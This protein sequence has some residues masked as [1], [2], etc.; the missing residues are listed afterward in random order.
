MSDTRKRWAGRAGLACGFV[1]CGLLSPVGAQQMTDAQKSAIRDNCRSDYMQHCSSVPP[2]TAQSLA[3]LQQNAGKVSAACQR[4]L[5][6]V[7]G[8]GAPQRTSKPSQSAAQASAN[9]PQAAPNA[10]QQ[11]VASSEARSWPVT[12]A[13][14]RGSAVIYQ[15]QVISWPEQRTLNARIALALVPAAT[16][17]ETLGTIE[18]AF[19]TNSDLATPP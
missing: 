19:R 1:A 5:G 12:V 13:N 8:S 18:V 4:A 2:G 10:A 9:G 15:P 16:R 14:E 6:A 11:Q 3:C 17:K 7:S